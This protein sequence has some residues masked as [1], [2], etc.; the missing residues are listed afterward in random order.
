MTNRVP[1]VIVI[2][3][4]EGNKLIH[5]LHIVTSGVVTACEVKRNNS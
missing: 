1:Y 4:T 3:S 2:P 5:K